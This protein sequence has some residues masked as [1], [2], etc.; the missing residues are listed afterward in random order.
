MAGVA[1]LVEVEGAQHGF[2][3]HDDPQ[4]QD[5]QTREWQGYVIRT[6]VKWLT[7]TD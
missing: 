2:A 1:S 6:V 5:P 7:T 3:V 4:Y